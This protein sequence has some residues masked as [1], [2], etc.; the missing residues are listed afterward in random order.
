MASEL[1]PSMP[2][3]DQSLIRKV[4]V[5]QSGV[6]KEVI[7]LSATTVLDAVGRTNV[8]GLDHRLSPSVVLE[9]QGTGNGGMMRSRIGAIAK[10]DIHRPMRIDEVRERHADSRLGT[11]GAIKL[12]FARIHFEHFAVRQPV[13]EKGAPSGPGDA[14]QVP[15]APVVPRMPIDGCYVV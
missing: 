6:Q 9:N 10:C 5:F 14:I 12:K 2:G 15:D 7:G 4:G 3:M 8:I 13:V 1:A 11:D